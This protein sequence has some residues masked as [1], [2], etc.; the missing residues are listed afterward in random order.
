MKT[1]M[2]LHNIDLTTPEFRVATTSP[3]QFETFFAATEA[4]ASSTFDANDWRWQMHAML[5]QDIAPGAP[6]GSAATKIQARVL[7]INAKQDHMVNPT[8]ALTLAPLIHAQT[9]V[10]EGMCG[11][12]APSCEVEKIRPA[13]Q[14]TLHK[15]RRIWRPVCAHTAAAR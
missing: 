15:K 4:G 14:A 6:L 1:V 7:V 3:A 9:I 11:H 10:L 5:T 12:I 2:L 13:I 8:P